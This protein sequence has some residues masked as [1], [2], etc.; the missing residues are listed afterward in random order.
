MKD[1]DEQQQFSNRTLSVNMD[2]QKSS[3]MMQSS[4]RNSEMTENSG[5][6]KTINLAE[7]GH[8]QLKNLE[9]EE[10]G[11]TTLQIEEDPDLVVLTDYEEDLSNNFDR[12]KLKNSFSSKFGSLVDC[13]I[14]N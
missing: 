1:L 9:T 2:S 7:H 5:F 11:M 8:A 13:F 12:N 3:R 14:Q 10:I 4:N 6:Y